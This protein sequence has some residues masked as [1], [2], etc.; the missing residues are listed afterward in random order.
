MAAGAVTAAVCVVLLLLGGILELGMY[1]A[2]ML[3]GLCAMPVGKRWGGK[4]Q[5]MVWLVVSALSFLLV[6]QI[7]E[8]LLFAAF[9]GWYPI[10]RPR[11]EKLPGPLR[12]VCKLLIFN[13]AIV[14]VEALVMCLLIPEA[15]ESVLALAL[16]A[17]ANVTFVMYD[18]AMARLEG[19]LTAAMRKARR[20]PS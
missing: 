12:W 1:A 20:H 19:I 17:L 18:F 13:G 14:A 8:N 11:L 6:P 16:L 15:V 5:C 2:P 7:E 9:F 4:Y 3:A 10:A